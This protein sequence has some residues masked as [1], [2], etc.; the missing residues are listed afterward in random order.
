MTAPVAWLSGQSPRTTD[1]H[2]AARSGQD[3][4]AAASLGLPVVALLSERAWAGRCYN[5]QVAL[6]VTVKR[7]ADGREKCKVRRY[8]PS[9]FRSP[10]RSRSR[11]PPPVLSPL[12]VD[13]GQS[14][15]QGQD[16]ELELPSVG[17]GVQAEGP[18]PDGQD[19]RLLEL[20]GGQSV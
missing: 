14:P 3:L 18:L 1:E 2:V 8:D 13:Y 16:T 6:H 5:C 17:Q 15:P 20:F 11:S 10:T 19:T 4:G 12:R 9:R 7:W